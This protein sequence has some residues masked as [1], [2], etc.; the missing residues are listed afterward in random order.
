MMIT[1]RD[2]LKLAGSTVYLPFVPRNYPKKIMF[3]GDGVV[4]GDPFNQTTGPGFRNVLKAMIPEIAHIGS[5][6]GNHESYTGMQTADLIPLI[7]IATT[8][9]SPDIV[10]IHTG[11]FDV[12]QKAPPAIAELVS[13]VKNNLPDARIIVSKIIQFRSFNFLVAEYNTDVI[14]EL[15]GVEVLHELEDLLLYKDYYDDYFPSYMGHFKIAT[16]I[17]NY[18]RTKS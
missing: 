16:T 18:L 10:F 6:S 15:D 2:F 4:R 17:S 1:R 14:A 7:D 3:V 5:Q 13:V 8:S 12:I 9:Y 11:A